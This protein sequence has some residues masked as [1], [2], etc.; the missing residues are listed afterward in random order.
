MKYTIK[1]KLFLVFALILVIVVSTTF[2]Y[3]T[4]HHTK[5]NT[6]TSGEVKV[7]LAEP[8]YNLP[9]NEELRKDIAPRQEIIKDP[10]VT[11]T[12]KSDCFIF[13]EVMIPN[14]TFSIVNPDGS[15]E[16]ALK[17]PFFSYDLAENWQSV[18]TGTVTRD[19]ID[20]DTCVYAYNVSNDST[21]GMSTLQPGERTTPLFNKNILKAPNFVELQ[22]PTDEIIEVPIQVYAIQSSDLVNTGQYGNIGIS[23]ATDVW[24]IV[25]S[26]ILA[27]GGK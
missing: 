13:I 16:P 19:G 14:L 3:Y 9:E 26:Q 10:V 23:K 21:Q 4:D 17:Q 6:F 1:N 25:K 22:V 2:A 8:E 24:E 7:E 15:K 20:Y 5:V 11:N 18:E 27:E 12:G